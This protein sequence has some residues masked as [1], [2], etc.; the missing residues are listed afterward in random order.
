MPLSPV[1][2]SH[3]NR[4]Y[5]QSQNLKLWLWL[6]IILCLASVGSFPLTSLFLSPEDYAQLT[7]KQP[8]PTPA[9]QTIVDPLNNWSKV[10]KHTDNLQF[11]KNNSQFFEGDTSLLARWNNAKTHEEITWHLQGMT[12]F[13][14]VTYF[15]PQEPISHFSIYISADAINWSEVSPTI[16]GGK[17]NWTRYDYHVKGLTGVNFIKMRWNNI[18]GQAWSPQIS[19]VTLSNE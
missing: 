10:Y 14:A 12:S 16:T 4:E 1:E 18:T 11:D 5:Q 9:H 8:S 2:Q 17:G 3:K 19:S 15:W 6:L 7:T 13:Q